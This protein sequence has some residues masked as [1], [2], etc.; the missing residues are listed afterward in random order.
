MLWPFSTL[1]RFETALVGFGKFQTNHDAGQGLMA[2]QPI[3]V[4]LALSVVHSRTETNVCLTKARFH[5]PETSE[6]VPAVLLGNAHSGD[7]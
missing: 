7:G 2:D 5:R 6:N 3:L 4:L 1:S